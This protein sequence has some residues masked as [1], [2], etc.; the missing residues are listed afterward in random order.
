M[1]KYSVEENWDHLSD[2]EWMEKF[3]EKIDEFNAVGEK[4]PSRRL[5]MRLWMMSMYEVSTTNWLQKT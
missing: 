3:E 4:L 1:A 5:L 2:A